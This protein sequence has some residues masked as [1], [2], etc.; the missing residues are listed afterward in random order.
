VPVVPWEE[1]KRNEEC[2]NSELYAGRLMIEARKRYASKLAPTKYGD[3]INATV[4]GP[5]GGPGLTSI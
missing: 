5:D 3:K 4:S 1:V 2:K